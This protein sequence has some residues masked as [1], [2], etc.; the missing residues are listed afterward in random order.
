MTGPEMTVLDMTACGT[1][2]REL[3]GEL[4]MTRGIV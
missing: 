1:T 2:G 3:T 4:D